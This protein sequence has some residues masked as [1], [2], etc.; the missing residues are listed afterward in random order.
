MS[1]MGVERK[2]RRLKII[3]ISIWYMNSLTINLSRRVIR[4]CYTGKDG[5]L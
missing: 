4:T 1:F 3:K 2:I 5:D